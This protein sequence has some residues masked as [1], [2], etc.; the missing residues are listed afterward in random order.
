M[1]LDKKNRDS[2]RA[3]RLD[4]VPELKYMGS[5]DDVTRFVTIRSCLRKVILGIFMEKGGS[6]SGR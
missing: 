1:A 6:C 4:D 5:A 3:W 2:Y